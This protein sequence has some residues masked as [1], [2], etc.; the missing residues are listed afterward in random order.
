MRVVF[1]RPMS[2][3][4]SEPARGASSI[5]RRLAPW[6]VALGLLAWL[7][8][9]VPVD[10]L[11]HALRNAPLGWFAGF[12]VIYVAGTLAGDT[13]ATWATFRSALPEAGLELHEALELRGA[14]YL[15][16]VVHYGAGQGGMAYFVNRVHKV[17]LARAAGAVMLIM[18]VNVVVVA[19]IAFVG[20]LAGGAPAS[21]S[22]RLVVLGLAAGFPAYLA[23]IAAKPAFLARRALLAPLFDA[24]LRGHA[25]AVAARLPHIAWLILGHWTAMRLF[26][27]N[28]PPAQA[29]TLL[30]LLFVVAVLPIAPSGIGTAPATAVALFS[31]YAADGR[32]AVLAYALA[33]QFGAMILQAAVGLA[34][35]RRV[36]KAVTV[37]EGREPAP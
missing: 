16:A 1:L 2:A 32:A 28:V 24:G 31:Q 12:V 3:P 5:A 29:L 6:A 20:V 13:F 17:P 4:A 37:G 34:F 14:S 10:E 22:L 35:L 9:M 15:L 8:H 7:F 11:E 19:L 25:V 26:G 21:P 27:V 36:T 33:L 18:G 30:P 23:V